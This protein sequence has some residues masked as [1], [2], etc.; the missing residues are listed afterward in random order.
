MDIRADARQRVKSTPRTASYR[1]GTIDDDCFKR[2]RPYRDPDLSHPYRTHTRVTR[3]SSSRQPFARSERQNTSFYRVP[4]RRSVYTSRVHRLLI[5]FC[6][7]SFPLLP[8]LF[9]DSS[10][11]FHLPRPKAAH[12]SQSQFSISADFSIRLRGTAAPTP[13]AAMP[14]QLL[15]GRQVLS[16]C[17]LPR[18][19]VPDATG[20]QPA[21]RY[22]GLKSAGG[23]SSRC[24]PAG[25]SRIFLTFGQPNRVDATTGRVKTERCL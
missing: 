24:Y 25:T 2:M 16:T 12:N 22:R 6:S 11:L 8:P 14:R 4:T 19:H 9:R 15:R 18:S 13:A 17:C 1:T 20:M 3:T 21:R 10:S 23:S 5:L 7:L